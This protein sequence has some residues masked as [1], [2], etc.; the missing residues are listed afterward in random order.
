MTMKHKLD[1]D[2]F[3]D[4]AISDAFTRYSIIHGPGESNLSRVASLAANDL[5]ENWGPE[6]A[7]IL[8]PAIKKQME[9]ELKAAQEAFNRGR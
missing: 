2:L 1:F 6:I 7:E 9:E 4:Q 5:L 3:I 8:K